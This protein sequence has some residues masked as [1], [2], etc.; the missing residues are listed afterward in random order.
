MIE[1]IL[2]KLFCMLV[3]GLFPWAWSWGADWEKQ[4]DYYYLTKNNRNNFSAVGAGPNEFA[5]KYLKY[6]KI[7]FLV[8]GA[9]DWQDYG[10]LNLEGNNMF[11]LPIDKAIKVEE[12]HFLAGGNYSNSYE[13]DRLMRLYGDKYF[14]ATLSVIFVYQDGAFRELSVPV[15]WDWFKL[16]SGA[17][18]KDGAGIK[19]LGENPVRKNC[20]FYQISFINPRPE[21]RVK[22]ILITDSWIGERPFSDVFAVTLKSPDML[23]TVGTLR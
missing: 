15:F 16:G 13:H 1:N 9:G 3:I 14:Y 23:E 10:R 18:L 20:S 5:S 7:N 21:Q 17:W 4:G 12:L 8:Q 22:N 2:K 19:S 6:G 11:L